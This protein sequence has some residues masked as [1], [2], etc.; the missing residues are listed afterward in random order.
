MF[1]FP[2]LMNQIPLSHTHPALEGIQWFNFLPNGD[3]VGHFATDLQP[4]VVGDFALRLI[5]TG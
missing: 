3:V 1:F 2:L 5:S 4:F